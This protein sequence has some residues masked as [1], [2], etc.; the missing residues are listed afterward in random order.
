V[1]VS[2]VYCRFVYFSY[3]LLKFS[4]ADVR[5]TAFG[6]SVQIG[7]LSAAIAAL[8]GSQLVMLFGGSYAMVGAVMSTVYLFGIIGSL[9]LP[10]TSGEVH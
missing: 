3:T 10:E 4:K 2:F 9:F 8:I 5:G 6:F 1:L 7:R